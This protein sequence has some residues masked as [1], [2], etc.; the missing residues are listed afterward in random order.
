MIWCRREETL[1]LVEAMKAACLQLRDRQ[2]SR[3]AVSVHRITED[4][5]LAALGLVV[6]SHP[7]VV[8]GT[9]LVDLDEE[10]AWGP[11]HVTPRRSA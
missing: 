5:A 7:I 10:T 11:R 1:D 4:T 8:E 9:S 6:G 3:L 2:G